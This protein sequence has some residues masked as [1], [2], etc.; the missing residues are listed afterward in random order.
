[1]YTASFNQNNEKP[2]EKLMTFK[3]NSTNIG[4]PYDRDRYETLDYILTRNRWKNTVKDVESDKNTTVRSDHFAMTAKIKVKLKAEEKQTIATRTKFEKLTEEHR[5][6]FNK[7]MKENKGNH[8]IKEWLFEN[9]DT[10]LPK[11]K[12]KRKQEGISEELILIPDSL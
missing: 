8:G 10:N 5:Y 3:Q 1:M 12:A 6:E 2:N 7:T 11:I 9:V 4:P